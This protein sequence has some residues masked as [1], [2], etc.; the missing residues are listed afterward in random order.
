MLQMN[1]GK[2]VYFYNKES[3]SKYNNTENIILAYQTENKE[4]SM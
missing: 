2:C 4:M 1:K 3:T